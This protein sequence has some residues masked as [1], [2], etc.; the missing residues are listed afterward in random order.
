M[1]SWDFMPVVPGL[2]FG[3]ARLGPAR[4]PI[5]LKTSYPPEWYALLM[6]GPPRFYLIDG[7]NLLRSPGSV[8][9]SAGG[10]RMLSKNIADVPHHEPFSFDLQKYIFET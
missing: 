2:W 4:Y 3:S 7:L 6:Q 10:V 9:R 8:E 5:I 1:V